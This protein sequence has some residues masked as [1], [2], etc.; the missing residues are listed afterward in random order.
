MATLTG[1]KI[2][3]SYDGLLKAKDNDA[4][5]VTKKVITDGLG[6]DT[7]LELSQTEAKVN[8]NLEVTGT[9]TGSISGNAATATKL[10]TPRTISVSGDVAGST[11]FDG[12]AN[13]SI[14]ATIQPNSVELGTDTTGDYVES[15]AAGTGIGVSGASGE[16]SVHTISNTGVISNV[17]G[18]GISVDQAT[19]DVTITNDDKG[20]SQNIFKNI[21]VAGQDSVV[22]GTNNDTLT[23]EASTNVTI[24][25]D[26]ATNKVVISANDTSI[27]WSEIQGKPDV[28]ISLDGDLTGSGTLTELGD[29]TITASVDT[30]NRINVGGVDSAGSVI[31]STFIDVDDD[32]YYVNPAT[33]A[34]IND[35]TVETGLTINGNTTSTSF[36]KSGGVSSEFLKADGSVDS[37]SY[38]TAESDTIQSVSDRGATTTNGLE[39]ASFTVTGGASTQFL[40]ADG[41]LDSNTYLTSAPSPNNSTINISAGGGLSGG[42]SFTLNQATDATVTISHADTSSVA[43][44]VNG[45]DAFIQNIQF[46]TYGHVTGVTSASPFISDSTVEVVGGYGIT[47]AQTFTLNDVDNVTIN[48]SHSDTSPL[49]AGDYSA[50]AGSFVNS[51]NI[52]EAGHIQSISTGAPAAPS[53]TLDDVLTNGNTTTQWIT[54]GSFRLSNSSFN[55]DLLELNGFS[56]YSGTANRLDIGNYGG[57]I[58][59]IIDF[60]VET[61]ETYYNLQVGNNINAAGDIIAF[62]SSDA[63]LKDNV[64]EIPN[65]L[66]KVKSIRGVHF[67][68]ND[69]Q[70]TYEHG[71]ADVGVI[72][73]EV[74]AVL[75]DIVTTRDNGYKAVKYEKL[76]AVLIEAV[77]ELSNKVEQL[78]NKLN[79]TTN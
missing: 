54:A 70:D 5:G 48:I 53:L 57:A 46:D 21:A 28:T 68:W 56:F 47:A 8:G 4:I 77:K 26:A 42:D 49:T 59:K 16:G 44:T 1:T 23:L 50:P 15:V 61:V 71:S 67:D 79:G 31:A 34:R 12:S 36:I 17:G 27:N 41:T 69:N 39:A 65:S 62:S 14:V 22:A 7:S 40:K 75:P 33:S 10:Q 63:R 73:Q 30:T 32:T 66:D 3:D 52:D 78:E 11:T 2:K 19:G 60:N 18:D 43:D 35:L 13:A 72:A 45:S 9:V 20:S 64:R 38:L 58:G 55:N 24:T 37:N 51:I 76:T 6:N 74:E 29:G 25:T